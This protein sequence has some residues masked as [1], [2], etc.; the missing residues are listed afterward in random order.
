MVAVL[1]CQLSNLLNYEKISPETRHLPPGLLSNHSQP[2]AFE[3]ARIEPADFLREPGLSAGQFVFLRGSREISGSQQDCNRSFAVLRC[4]LR[5]NRTA[6]GEDH[7]FPGEIRDFA[8]IL[9]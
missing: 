4:P 1:S 7:R 6:G 8:E 2:H 3:P 9:L 5:S